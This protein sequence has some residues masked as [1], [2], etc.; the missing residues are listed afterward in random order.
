MT[1]ISPFRLYGILLIGVIAMGWS[2]ILIRLAEAPP[3]AIAAYRMLGGAGLLLAFTWKGIWPAWQGLS[4]RERGLWLVSALALSFHFAFWVESLRHTSVAS[5]VILVTTNPIFAGLGGYFV[6]REKETPALWAGVFCTVLGGAALAWSDAYTWAG[7]SYGNLLALA[8]A[9][10]AS[11]Y[12]LCGRRLRGQ[13]S[14]GPYITVCYGLSGL[15]LMSGGWLAGQSL[16][17]FSIE[18][19]LLL[20]A[21]ALG[22]TLLGHTSVNYALRYLSSGKVAL[23]IVGEPLV[24]TVLA[25]W[26]LAEPL[27]LARSVSGAL[28]LTGIIWGGRSNT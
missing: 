3:M 1:E 5:S 11:V 20:L 16:G 15:L 17:G 6:L 21:M 12:L 23:I 22:P 4:P 10:M 2:A 19:W 9:V 13:I 8:G 25:W 7:S 28:M 18:T 27:T 14:L 24:A 26:I